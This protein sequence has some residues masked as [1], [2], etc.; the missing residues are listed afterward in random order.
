MVIRIIH[1]Q[2]TTGS[3]EKLGPFIICGAWIIIR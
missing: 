2:V 1:N 3:I